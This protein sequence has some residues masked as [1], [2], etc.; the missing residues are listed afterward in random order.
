MT[1]VK[2]YYVLASKNPK[3]DKQQYAC[4][5]EWGDYWGDN[6]DRARKY[7][8]ANPTP[9][10]GMADKGTMAKGRNLEV[11]KIDVVLSQS[12]QMDQAEQF[13]KEE[14]VKRLKA[15]QEELQ[16]QIDGIEKE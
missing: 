1:I 4:P 6:F 2:T 3:T 15:Q 5:D 11:W 10:D 7:D 13:A 16:R 12:V 14:L 9:V 8:V